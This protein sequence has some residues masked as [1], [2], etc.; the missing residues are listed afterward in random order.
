MASRR[1]CRGDAQLGSTI[2]SGFGVSGAATLATA[3]AANEAF[4]LE[5]TR[6][7]LVE[8]AHVAEVEAGTGLGD[9]FVQARG[10][11]VWNVGDGI[12]RADCDARTGSHP[13]PK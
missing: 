11:L 10:G 12:Q 4:S 13:R 9:V 1:H 8:A 7:E 6:E 2:G 3:L 5:W